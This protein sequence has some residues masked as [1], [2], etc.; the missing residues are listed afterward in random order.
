MQQA[1]G[2]EEWYSA[3]VATVEVPTRGSNKGRYMYTIKYDNCNDVF[4]FPLLED[5]AAG[6][7]RIEIPAGAFFVGK[8][9]EHRFKLED[10][11]E[12][13]FEGK[14]VS[15]DPSTKV[16]TIQYRYEEEE[17]E[18]EEDDLA[19]SISQEPLLLDYSNNDVRILL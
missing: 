5:L 16:H 15:F 8:R 6:D 18:E 12:Y 19:A 17:E 11:E 3:I 1:K 10:G 14:V 7:L 13:W 4:Q 2:K 9:I